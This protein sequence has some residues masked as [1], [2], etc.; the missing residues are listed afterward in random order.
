MRASRLAE[1]LLP[2]RHI[3]RTAQQLPVVVF[4]GV[5]RSARP[6]GIVLLG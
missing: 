2:G 1:P 4:L 5:Y 6:G 3:A